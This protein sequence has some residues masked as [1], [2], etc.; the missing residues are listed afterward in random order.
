[1]ASAPRNTRIPVASNVDVIRAAIEA[2]NMGDL[3][4]MLALADPGLFHT[5]P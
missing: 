3:D 5:R 2:F 1:M 4:A